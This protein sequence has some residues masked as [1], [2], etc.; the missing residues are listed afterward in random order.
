MVSDLVSQRAQKQTECAVEVIAVSAPALDCDPHNGLDRIDT[1]YLTR[2]YP[3]RFVRYAFYV[4][5]MNAL[6][7]VD[8]RRLERQTESPQVSLL[9]F[10]I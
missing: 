4:A 9:Q 10:G 5:T 8:G 2:M 6:Q 7:C 3:H 1:P